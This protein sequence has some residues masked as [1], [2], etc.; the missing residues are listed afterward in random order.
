M[1]SKNLGNV[2]EK[3][4]RL[5]LQLLSPT[6]RRILTI[7]TVGDSLLLAKRN[8]LKPLKEK[9]VDQEVGQEIRLQ[10]ILVPGKAGEE[11]H[12]EI[13]NQGHQ[14]EAGAEVV[15]GTLKEEILLLIN[16]KNYLILQ[17]ILDQAHLREI[18]QGTSQGM[19]QGR[20]LE[21]GPDIGQ[22]KVK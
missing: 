11:I 5:K 8:L 12:P 6:Q 9:V 21:K 2:F 14:E 17:G 22:V 20:V 10:E 15:G 7:L 4:S 1:F 18:D 19:A 13:D 3:L 16:T